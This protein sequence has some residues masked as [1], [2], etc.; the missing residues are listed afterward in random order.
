MQS[1]AFPLLLFKDCLLNLFA[2]YYVNNFWTDRTM[3]KAT[4]TFYI[5]LRF[6]SIDGL[7]PPV[8]FAV[9][10]S[11]TLLIVITTRIT[12]QM[13]CSGWGSPG[14][15][16]KLLWLD[17]TIPILL[18]LS[19]RTLP[20]PAHYTYKSSFWVGPNVLRMAHIRPGA[21]VTLLDFYG[22]PDH[23]RTF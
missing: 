11:E 7:T 13:L 1:C 14:A 18:G 8:A 23:S 22:D 16:T 20:L 19:E 15:L 3:I 6:N 4:S 12:Y 2:D 21:Q 9:Y 10:V 5:Y 17:H